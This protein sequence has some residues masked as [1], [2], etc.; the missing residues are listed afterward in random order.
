[1]Y[2]QV[3]I[4]GV[5]PPASSWA[6]LAAYAVCLTIVGGIVFWLGEESYLSLIHI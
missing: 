1:M 2:R 6:M 5:T 3:I 4:E